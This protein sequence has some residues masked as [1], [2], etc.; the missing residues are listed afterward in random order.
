MSL[1]RPE[2][3]I[4]GNEP[5]QRALAGA[6]E[7]NR[8]AHAYLFSGPSRVGRRA[9]AIAVAKTSNCLAQARRAYDFCGHCRSCRL[10]PGAHPD[11]T[12]VGPGESSRIGIDVAR[13]IRNLASLRPG[14]SRRRFIIIDDAHR[15]T[16][17]A[18][19]ALLKTLEEP[20]A[21]TTLVLIAPSAS[22]LPETVSSRCQE[23]RFST[24]PAGQIGEGLI[25]AG[26]DPA[27]A[28]ELA[29]LSYGRPGWALAALS[30][31][32]LVEARREVLETWKGLAAPGLLER[33]V[34]AAELANRYRATGKWTLMDDLDIFTQ[35]WKEA[36]TTSLAEGDSKHLHSYHK[37]LK[38]LQTLQRRLQFNVNIRLALEATALELP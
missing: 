8:L 33:F 15:M 12:L 24:V 23:I 21:Y 1:L 31:P 9:V 16:S 20:S 36:L 3:K 37:A 25:E 17:E 32:S 38:A 14:T 18:A 27:R 7:T 6:L 28:E 2:W 19:N 35:W 4:I 34:A 30:E 26:C 11:V 22:S 29:R 5:A 13:E 10:I